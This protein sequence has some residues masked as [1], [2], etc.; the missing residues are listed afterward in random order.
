MA[1][2]GKVIEQLRRMF[3]EIVCDRLRVAHPGA[4]DDGLWFFRHPAQGGEV[5]VES[6]TGNLPFLIE[7][8]DSAERDTA[9][10]VDEAVTL[11]AARL[12]LTPKRRRR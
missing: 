12:E 9:R 2:I 11:I 5:Q 1:D 6:A 4:D 10:S 3:P 7:S 8:D